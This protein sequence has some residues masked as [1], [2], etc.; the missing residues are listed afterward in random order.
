MDDLF[1]FPRL[2]T[3]FQPLKAITD[4]KMKMRV[5]DEHCVRFTEGYQD[6]L[7]VIDKMDIGCN[8]TRLLRWSDGFH[9]INEFQWVGNI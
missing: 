7:S 1:D 6:V 2:Y 9:R 4:H 3:H 5:R 8:A